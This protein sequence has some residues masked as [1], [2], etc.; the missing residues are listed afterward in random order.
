MTRAETRAPLNR[1]SLVR[2]LTDKQMIGVSARAEDV[3]HQLSDWLNFRQAIALHS[4]LS[5]APQAPSTS[6]TL[7]RANLISP[8]ALGQHVDKVRAAL[9]QSIVQGA[10][11]GTGLSRIEMPRA[12]LDEALEPKTAFE[13]YRRFITAHQRQMEAVLS[14]LRAQLRA[15]LSQR[16]SLQPLAALDAQFE[17]IL[18]ER[19]TQLLGKV[20]RLW[21]K[22]FVQACKQHLK[23][24]A[25]ADADAP[26]EPT[27]PAW[28][29]TLRQELRTALLAELDVRLQPT[30]GLLEAFNPETPA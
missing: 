30:L 17:N 10:A 29:M 27:P 8:E 12:E 18:N 6:P 25:L 22:R 28:L 23:K 24:Q 26:A 11:P 4:L 20:A 16:P 14:T 21:E 2:F 5:P 7:R 15:Q 3:G 1:S 9:E 19:E 13:P